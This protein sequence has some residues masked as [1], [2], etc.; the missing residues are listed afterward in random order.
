MDSEDRQLGGQEE[1]K[2]E[3]LTAFQN[4]FPAK[5]TNSDLTL[6]FIK[7]FSLKNAMN[8]LECFEKEFF[9]TI[10]SVINL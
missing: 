1:A 4:K 2:S 7:K 8:F 3:N 9:K 6:F 10:S 5:I